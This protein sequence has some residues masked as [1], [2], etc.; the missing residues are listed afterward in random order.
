MSNSAIQWRLS[1]ESRNDRTEYIGPDDFY[2]TVKQ[3]KRNQN[4]IGPVKLEF[5]HFDNRCLQ[6]E[7]EPELLKALQDALAVARE[8]S[9]P[10]A[11]SVTNV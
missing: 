10:V 8:W 3:L 6:I 4:P 5:T 7:R 1:Y 11:S 2:F 9:Q